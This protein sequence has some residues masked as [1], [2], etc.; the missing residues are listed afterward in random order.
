MDAALIPT[1]RINTEAPSAETRRRARLVWLQT[2]QDLK[3]ARHMQQQNRAHDAR[4]LA[5]QVAS[6]A[7]TT[8]AML[9]GYFQF[10]YSSPTQMLQLCEEADPRL[11]PLREACQ[12]LEVAQEMDPFTN[13]PPSAEEEAET[14]AQ[15]LLDAEAIRTAVFG[16]LKQHKKEWIKP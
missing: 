16:V 11:T 14:M 12:R 3:E 13:E 1:R 9:L 15:L 6:N 10:P 2:A 4:F 5:L 7:L 8:V